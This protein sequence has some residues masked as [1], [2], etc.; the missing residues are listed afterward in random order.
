MGPTCQVEVSSH[1]G[2]LSQI[3]VIWTSCG[4]N[5]KFSVMEMQFCKLMMYMAPPCKFSY[6][7]L[8]V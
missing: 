7:V 3:M 2:G 4:P 1:V 8:P 5:S 6:L